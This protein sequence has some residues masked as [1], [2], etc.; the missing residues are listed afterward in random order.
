MIE[1]VIT[2]DELD[3]EDFNG[4]PATY[5]TLNNGTISVDFEEL[6]PQ[7]YNK[8]SVE[9]TENI[10]A[11]EHENDYEDRDENWI[12]SYEPTLE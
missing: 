8:T 11:R 5:I 2:A 4:I 12:L 9:L 6:D 1:F 10:A 3:L 7:E